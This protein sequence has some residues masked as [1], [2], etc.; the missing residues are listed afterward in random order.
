MTTVAMLRSSAEFLAIRYPYYGDLFMQ[1]DYYVCQ[2]E[3]IRACMHVYVNEGEAN[4]K[5]FLGCIA[6]T[7][8]DSNCPHF[9]SLRITDKSYSQP[10]I[11]S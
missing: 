4:M 9:P 6:P 8:N 10:Y 2:F 7:L 11:T 1:K 5:L 3:V